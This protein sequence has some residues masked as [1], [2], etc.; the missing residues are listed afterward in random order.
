VAE[1]T[2]ADVVGEALTA[3]SAL[4]AGDT[5]AEARAQRLRV[6]VLLPL[7]RHFDAALSDAP[8]PHTRAPESLV[9]TAQAA[10]IAA[11][12]CLLIMASGRASLR[13][14][15]LR[16][17][18]RLGEAF[19]TLNL[20]ATRAL[21]V[22]EPHEAARLAASLRVVARERSQSTAPPPQV[23]TL[24]LPRS[25]PSLRA[26]APRPQSWP[27]PRDLRSDG[28]ALALTVGA[29][30]A[31]LLWGVHAARSAIAAHRA[32]AAI[33]ASGSGARAE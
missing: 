5:D 10:L 13:E 24:A 27:A 20:S 12:A 19:C 2:P 17:V 14:D 28:V 23:P 16:E 15:L 32:A 4:S 30:I 18:S 31:A 21:G 1:I 25:G 33:D 6:E 8:E 29:L 11:R 22:P 7:A 26:P 3:F 9:R